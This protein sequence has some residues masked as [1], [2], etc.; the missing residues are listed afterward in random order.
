MAAKHVHFR[1]IWLHDVARIVQRVP[2]LDWSYLASRSSELRMSAPV[3]AALEAAR[4]HAGAA[5]DDAHLGAILGPLGAPSRWSLEHRDLARLRQHVHGLPGHDL[6]V[7]GPGIWPLRRRAQP[8][9]RLA[10][11]AG[12]AALGDAPR[13]RVPSRTGAPTRV[14]PAAGITGSLKRLAIRAGGRARSSD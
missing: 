5:I 14:G 3:A 7:D 2:G 6:T 4:T 11:P 10:R 13:P 12:S 8:R 1:L 9:A